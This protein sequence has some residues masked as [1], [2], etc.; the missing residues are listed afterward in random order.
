MPEDALAALP[1]E[2]RFELVLAE[3][4]QAEERGERPDPSDLLRRFPEL[5]TQLCTFLRNRARFDRLAPRL[6]PTVKSGAAPAG[7]EAEVPRRFGDYAVLEPVGRGGRGIVYRVSDPELNRP[8]AVKV[9]RPEL[10]DDADAVRRFREEA[11]VMGQLQHPGIVPVHGLGRLPDGRPYF[12][13]K[14][15][16]GR[17]LA[18]LL[19]ARPAPAED[20]PRFLAIFQQVCQAVA[21]AHSRGVIHRDLKPANVMVGAFAEVQVMDWGLAKVLGEAAASRGRQPPEDVADGAADTVCTV[22][23]GATGLSSAD[24]L[25]VGTFAY[26]SPEQ[27]LGRVEHL[28]ARADVFGLGAVLCEILTG[29]P[30]YDGAPWWRLH[31]RAASAD[32]ADAFARLDACGADADL[33]A[34][35]RDCLAPERER[36]P[37]DAS[38]VATRLA[39]YL[40][41]V[42][43][44]L[45]RAELEKAAAQARAEEERRTVA[46]ERR[47]RRLKAGLAAAFLVLVLAAIGGFWW[48]QQR[49]LQADT[50]TFGAMAEASRLL[51]QAKRAPLAEASKYREAL[52]AAR[53]AVQLAHTGAAS[54]EVQ[55]QA[56][57]LAAALEQELEAADRDRQLVLALWEIHEPREVPEFSRDNNGVIA[58][59]ARPSANEQFVSALR[60]WGLDVTTTPTAEAARRL[61]ERPAAAVT[62]VAAALD[63]WASDWKGRRVA[64]EEWRRLADLAAALDGD[65]SPERREL[66]AILG[67]GNLPAERALGELSRALLP[68][69][70]LTGEVPG[71][72]RN[73]LRR[74]AERTDPMS[75]PVP[76]QLLLARA[77]RLAGDDRQAERL[78]RLAVRARPQDVIL[79]YSLGK[80]L[81]EQRPPKWQEAVACYEAVRALRPQFGVALAEALIQAGRPEQGLEMYERLVAEKPRDPSVHM[82]CAGALYHLRRYR[83]AEA[84]CRAAIKLQPDYYV[85]HYDLG[86]TLLGQRRY[87]EAELAYREALRL[88]SGDAPALGNLAVALASQEKYKEAEAACRQAIKLQPD[89]FTAYSNLGSFLTSQGRF[90]EGETAC[91]EAIRREPGNAGTHGM[92]GFVLHEQGR[93]REAEVCYR[94][95]IRLRPGYAE[96]YIN[97]AGTLT[98]QRRPREGEAVCRIA[99]SLR[100]DLPEAYIQLGNALHRQGRDLEAEEAYREAIRREPDFAK[101]YYNLGTA[102]SEQGK[103][104]ESEAEFRT[105][106][107][108]KPDD[109]GA[110]CNL[111]CVLL[112]Q[113][114]Y[115]EAEKA[116]REAIRLRHNNAEAHGNLASALMAMGDYK[117]GEAAC[118]EAI[119]IDPKNEGAHLALGN[120]L[121]GQRRYREAEAACREAVRLKGDY[122]MAHY[123]LGNVLAIQGKFGEAVI[124]Y[125]EAIALQPEYPEAHINLCHVLKDQGDFAGALEAVRAVQALRSKVPG[126]P[127]P[128]AQWVRQCEQLLELDR[129][130]SAVL[131]GKK[132]AGAAESLRLATFCLQHKHFPATAVRF[133]AKALADATAADPRTGHRY[134]AAQAA[135]LAAAGK[136][137]DASRLDDSKRASLRKQALDWLR[138]D[139]AGIRELAQD[140]PP[141]VRQLLAPALRH[142]Q[143]NPNLAS[144][145]AKVALADLP[146]GEREEWLKFW[147][148]MEALRK[149]LQEAR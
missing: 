148:D 137:A 70:A 115:P 63:E 90:K 124:E 120:A 45:R 102:L 104:R 61:R 28:D 41:A 131:Q 122:P 76:R 38:A 125:R 51:D 80:L 50:A 69:S 78:L 83:E 89:Y 26:M 42:Q 12:A 23:S 82:F 133:Y 60:A 135:A 92:L 31:Q 21:Y 99:I 6:A 146:A 33:I 54:A 36:R 25:V 47:A 74:L 29:A 85:Q 138:A 44:R 43:E 149:R 55:E 109:S 15:V 96:V 71:R 91:R 117:A 126:L 58:P 16:Q 77:L 30:P 62:E 141:E 27:A 17:T 32:L 111:G 147:S 101:A 113:H 19:A 100:P 9:L 22:R 8:L 97:L 118:R 121:F 48:A 132:P 66:R 39:T 53:K 123:N 10:R 130:L 67:R 40:A 20:R 119:S 136:G 81:E 140:G 56:A 145:R 37:P 88:N 79:R 84:R 18:D 128:P 134:R 24:G 13:M 11:Q 35:A 4:L 98:A 64:R 86:N 52:E 46:A 3:L 72:D 107:R 110:H 1:P 116:S 2:Q 108:L 106:I 105:A 139:L 7:P 5:E 34:L 59:I 112:K 144:L 87:R 129:R 114:R 73:R 127:Y 143:Q 93:H 94:E 103:L 57:A 49:R 142:W 95:A 65:S 14:L 68:L 75:E